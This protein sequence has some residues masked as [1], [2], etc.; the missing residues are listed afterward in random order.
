MKKKFNWFVALFFAASV[1]LSVGCTITVPEDGDVTPPSDVQS[2][3]A[4]EKD[5]IVTLSWK[6]PLDEDFDGVQI[7]MK[8][9]EGNF[10]EPIILSKKVTQY[11]VY[12]LTEGKEYNFTI[13]AFDENEN[14]SKGLS[15][16]VTI[17]VK[18]DENNPDDNK[19]EGSDP[20][21]GN[22]DDNKPEGNDPEGG[23]PD[24]N[25]PEGSD[26]EGGNP[27]D[28]KPEENEPDNGVTTDATK[29]LLNEAIELLM[30]VQLDE[31][32]AKIKEAYD[33]QK[34][35][36]T[37]MYYALAELASISVDQS[38]S[39]LL[40]ENFGIKNYPSTMN[41]LINTEW[42][43]EY[44]DIEKYAI[45]NVYVDSE[46]LAWYVRV[47]GDETYH[48]DCYIF[49][50]QL[51]DGTWIR[52]DDTYLTNIYLDENG[53][54]FIDMYMLPEYI[55]CTDAIKY[56]CDYTGEYIEVE[57]DVILAP[58]F[59]Q[60]EGMPAIDN[61]NDLSMLMI[62]NVFNCN[63]N[64]LND[65]V[66][67]VLDIFG[68]KFNTAKELISSMSN[69]SVELPEDLFVALELEELLGQS[70][71]K[72]GKAELNILIASMEILQGTFQWISS[73]DWS[74]NLG[75]FSDNLL[76]ETFTFDD[77]KSIINKNSLSARNEMA[78]DDSKNSFIEAIDMIL[79]SYDYLIG[80]TSDYPQAVIDELIKNLTVYK[81]GAEKLKDSIL[82]GTTF[83]LPAEE[84]TESGVW[85][86]DINNAAF[87]INFE[88]FF[89]P[90]YF[91]KL[92]ERNEDGTI[93][94]F[95]DGYYETENDYEDIP[96]M[97]ISSAESF[98]DISKMFVDYLTENNVNTEYFS[99]MKMRVGLNFKYNSEL[100]IDLLPGLFD[101]SDFDEPYFELLSF[102]ESN[103]GE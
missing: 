92:I 83:Y 59:I 82:S 41:A 33:G 24:D 89:T 84:L 51:D 75:F 29:A 66:D 26:P 102:S 86:T 47:N 11:K 99:Y 81:D 91:Y 71:L 31:G 96:M 36:E 12:E 42:L 44:K 85:P 13:K 67:N 6:N 69:A 28:N 90:G 50:K 34:N 2:F 77:F 45:L 79:E 40:T 8:P 3:F 58:E 74:A 10:E 20:E 98:E 100:L 37:K 97:D 25:K 39:N 46:Q 22:P 62:Y 52:D 15:C 38:V 68:T 93:K 7:S 30:N 87:G 23:N 14:F 56:V 21:G 72:I 78:M 55:D 95:A 70:S 73:Y 101:V 80:E 27:D 57:K 61:V 65:A 48:S 63:S 4:E 54:Y 88:K 5:G 32:I 9:S 53:P 35:D 1:L 16:S 49:A 103:F 17:S 43:K 18:S 94:W 64:G 19:P 76:G 60:P